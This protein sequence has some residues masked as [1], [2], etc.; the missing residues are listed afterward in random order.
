M[1][2]II[3]TNVL[4]KLNQEKNGIYNQPTVRQVLIVSNPTI[5]IEEFQLQI[6][7]NIIEIDNKKLLRCRSK[8]MKDIVDKLEFELFDIG[9]LDHTALVIKNKFGSE[10]SNEMYLG[11]VFEDGDE[12]IAQAEY[13]EAVHSFKN[14]NSKKRCGDSLR[15]YTTIKKTRYS[16]SFSKDKDSV[17]FIFSDELG[18]KS[19][20]YDQVETESDSDVALKDHQS[21]LLYGGEGRLNK[22]RLVPSKTQL[23]SISQKLESQSVSHSQLDSQNQSHI[24]LAL[25]RFSPDISIINPGVK[26]HTSNDENNF[27]SLKE[28][29]H[30]IYYSQFNESFNESINELPNYASTKAENY[31]VSSKNSVN[32]TDSNISENNFKEMGEEEKILDHPVSNE[33]ELVSIENNFSSSQAHMVLCWS[34]K[35]LLEHKTISSGDAQASL[36][37]S[38]DVESEKQYVLKAVQVVHEP[39]KKADIDTASEASLESVNNET[40]YNVDQGALYNIKDV[41]ILSMADT[42]TSEGGSLELENGKSGVKQIQN[43]SNQPSPNENFKNLKKIA[44][45]NIRQN[46]PTDNDDIDMFY[47]QTDTQKFSLSSLNLEGGD[48]LN[49]FKLVESDDFS[50]EDEKPEIT[51]KNND[52]EHTHLLVMNNTQE[53]EKFLA[54]HQNL[55][56]LTQKVFAYNQL[57]IDDNELSGDSTSFSSSSDDENAVSNVKKQI[58][59]KVILK[60]KSITSSP[61]EKTLSS[62]VKQKLKA[63]SQGRGFKKRMLSLSDI[64]KTTDF[65]S[66]IVSVGR[67]SF[68]NSFESSEEEEDD[69]SSVEP[70]LE[71]RNGQIQN[72]KN[73]LIDI[74][75]SS[76]STESSNEDNKGS[77]EEQV[78]KKNKKNSSVRLAGDTLKKEANSRKRKVS[79]LAGLANDAKVAPSQAAKVNLTMKNTAIARKKK[80]IDS[81]SQKKTKN[82]SIP[83]FNGTVNNTPQ[84][85]LSDGAKNKRKSSEIAVPLTQPVKLSFESTEEDS[86]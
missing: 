30:D 55:K 14:E 68:P 52:L 46:V 41:E 69:F 82:S 40:D 13:C 77:G 65:N 57:V 70:M 79:G 28:T 19:S 54:E 51:I 80:A 2:S 72:A 23:E 59:E 1:K 74:N 47:S 26:E 81:V 53:S 50:T 34:P 15:S 62:D 8:N 67:T 20:I 3:R 39:T 27:S 73:D 10:I 56:D 35:K 6:L 5:T 33:N 21:K 12:V 83:I 78:L 49:R 22:S 85:S 43:I 4:F 66:S 9:I 60:Q 64:A 31:T 38:T 42:T 25:G 11:E 76:D 48:K 37:K 75:I 18:K 29:P 36:Q 71:N 7:Q 17:D 58:N 61:S 45:N 44:K 32:G 63:T 86:I 16:L 84:G 24:S